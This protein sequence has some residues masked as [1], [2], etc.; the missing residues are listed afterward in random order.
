MPNWRRSALSVLVVVGLVGLGFAVSGLASSVEQT[1]LQAT[2]EETSEE[3]NEAP[4]VTKW[5]AGL[6][7]GQ[8]VPKPT[9]VK[10]NAGGTF[11][12]TLT[13]D[14]GKYTA[15]YKLTFR[16]LTGKAVAAHIH[17]AKP[18][19]SGPVLIPLCA[20]CTSGKSGKASVPKAAASAIKAG[21]AYV[22]VHTAKNAAGELRGQ[23]KKAG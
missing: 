11:T 1:G 18:G 7:T 20:P 6:T 3:T 17:R 10:A 19:K 16:N 21:A 23:V 5:R 15:S 9:G 12:F 4:K 22:N 14:Q 2:G 13:E 8:E